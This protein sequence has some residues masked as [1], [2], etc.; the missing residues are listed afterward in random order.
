MASTVAPRSTAMY[1]VAIVNLLFV[2]VSSV[3]N[4]Q[5]AY[6][7]YAS[8]EAF[9]DGWSFDFHI[10]LLLPWDGDWVLGPSVAGGLLVALDRIRQEGIVKSEITWS[11]RDTNCNSNAGV[12][13]LLDLLPVDVYIG[14][15]CSN[16]CEPV[17]QLSTATGIPFVSFGCTSAALSDKSKYGMFRRVVG[18]WLMLGPLFRLFLMRMNWRRVAIVAS[19]ERIYSDT[20]LEIHKSLQEAN[21]TVF[22]HYLTDMYD[23]ERLVEGKL[24]TM[25]S[26]EANGKFAEHRC[27]NCPAHDQTIVDVQLQEVAL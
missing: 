22:L 25:L 13:A 12:V 27:Y 18:T 10:G 1:V 7:D 20:G 9:T 8:D 19:T 24:A 21:L 26:T 16:V 3:T 4:D 17:A 11:W 6:D 2:V 14:G 5:T 15:G 23:G